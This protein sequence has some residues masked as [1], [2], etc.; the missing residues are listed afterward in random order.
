MT[1]RITDYQTAKSAFSGM[2]G[3]FNKDRNFAT[4]ITLGEGTTTINTTYA[5]IIVKVTPV[6]S[7][8]GDARHDF[9]GDLRKFGDSQSAKVADPP[10]WSCAKLNNSLASDG[11]SSDEDR[12]YVIGYEALKSL[13]TQEQIMDCLGRLV[14]VAAKIP[15]IWV[16]NP[17]LKITESWRP[18]P[19]TPST[20]ILLSS[21]FKPCKRSWTS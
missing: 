6:P 3:Q 14:K 10:A 2:L 17:D 9:T 16:D 13:T 4:S 21:R 11:L 5:T 20:R 7:L 12:A 15:K 1:S 8:I 18:K 19:M